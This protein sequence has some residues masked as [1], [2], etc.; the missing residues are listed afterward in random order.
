MVEKELGGE[1]Q[2]NI[3]KSELSP[4]RSTMYRTLWIAALF[5]YVGVAMYDV[6]RHG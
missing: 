1:K 3:S 2:E 4:L 6:G 5:S